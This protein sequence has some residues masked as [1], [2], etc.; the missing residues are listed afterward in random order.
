MKL[1]TMMMVMILMMKLMM[2]V[3]SNPRIVASG[4]ELIVINFVLIDK[5][6]TE[7]RNENVRKMK[8]STRTN[9]YNKH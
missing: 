4:V 8:S 5:I 3:L 6:I 7:W 2:I 9:D 1:T